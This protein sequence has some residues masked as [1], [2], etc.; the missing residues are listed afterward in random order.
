MCKL[1]YELGLISRSVLLARTL[2]SPY[3]L[4]ALQ[5]KGSTSNY[6]HMQDSTYFAS[7]ASKNK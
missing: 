2:L 3:L 6:L 7:S 1:L 4:A 5:Y